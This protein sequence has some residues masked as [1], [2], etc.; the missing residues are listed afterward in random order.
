MPPHVLWFLHLHRCKNHHLA[1]FILKIKGA[2]QQ[3]SVHF[4]KTNAEIEM[5]WVIVSCTGQASQNSASYISHNALWLHVKKY[6]RN[7]VSVQ[8]NEGMTA[9]VENVTTAYPRLFGM[10]TLTLFYAN[11]ILANFQHSNMSRGHAHD[12]KIAVLSVQTH[13]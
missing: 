8:I 12:A 1:T 2:L 5:S 3:F 10:L 4:Q 13:L 9:R 7:N 11:I 6:Q